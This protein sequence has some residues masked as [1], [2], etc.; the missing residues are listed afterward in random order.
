MKI[1]QLIAQETIHNFLEGNVPIRKADL[2]DLATIPW[3]NSDGVLLYI[4][5]DVITT[6]NMQEYL[7][8]D[9]PR[10]AATSLSFGQLLH[11]SG[12]VWYRLRGSNVT[13]TVPLPVLIPS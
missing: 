12:V 11:T 4:S 6:W 5:Q 1:F 8:T 2:A 9:P 13:I 7:E 3:S 10:N